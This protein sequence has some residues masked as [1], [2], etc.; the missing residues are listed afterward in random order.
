MRRI[1]ACL[2][3]AVV[4]MWAVCAA[5]SLAAGDLPREFAQQYGPAAEQLRQFY[6][7][8]TIAGALRRELPETGK[9]LEQR[10][11]YRSA[12]AQVRLDVT[13]TAS[14]GM[15]AKI[16]GS[17]MY[18]ATGIGSLTTIRR[19]GSEVF[20]DARQLSYDDSKSRIENTCLL[21]YPY[22]F[23]S[24]QTIYDFLTQPNVK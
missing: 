8:A 18:M 12:G 13:T 3:W 7:H 21:N 24:H 5:G 14:K 10:F 11:V 9:L 16:G 1:V 17:D 15:G 23:D 20:D 6:T 4:A 22:T 2:G 19:P